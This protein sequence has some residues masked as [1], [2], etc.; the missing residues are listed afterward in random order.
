MEVEEERSMCIHSLPEIAWSDLVPDASGA[1]A[2][3]RFRSFTLLP[4]LWF[5]GLLIA[6]YWVGA[7]IGLQLRIAFW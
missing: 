2:H 4:L 7:E 5:V 1:V 6:F 3:R